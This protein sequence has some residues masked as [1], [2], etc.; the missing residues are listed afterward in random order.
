MDSPDDYK[1]AVLSLSTDISDEHN[2]IQEVIR[3]LGST[4]ECFNQPNATSAPANYTRIVL[5]KVDRWG[6]SDSCGESLRRM[7]I[8]LGRAKDVWD[9]L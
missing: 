3:L 1:F 5:E 6:L 4:L 8:H 7:H 9:M 2:E